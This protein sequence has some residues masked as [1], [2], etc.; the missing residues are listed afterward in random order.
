MLLAC[1]DDSGFT[2]T[3]GKALY[4]WLFKYVYDYDER[5]LYKEWVALREAT[6]RK[7]QRGQSTKYYLDN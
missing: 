2:D 5:E 4:H 1:L 7:E 3:R 6:N